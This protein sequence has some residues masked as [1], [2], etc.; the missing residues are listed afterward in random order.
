VAS[1]GGVGGGCTA[2]GL[3]EPAH[4][5]IKGA[6]L[7]AQPGDVAGGRQVDQVQHPAGGALDPA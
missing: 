1:S 2:Y 7:L 6:D 5:A 3:V 4:A